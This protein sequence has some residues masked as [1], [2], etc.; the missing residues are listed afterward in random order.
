MFPNFHVPAEIMSE[1]FRYCGPSDLAAAS[2]VSQ[3]WRRAAFFRLHY[4]ITIRKFPHLETLLSRLESEK[5]DHDL[6][7]GLCLRSLSLIM[8][9]TN[10]AGKDLWFEWKDN[11]ALAARVYSVMSKLIQLEGLR[12]MTHSKY[13]SPPDIFGHC[14]N[15]CPNLRW[16]HIAITNW[17]HNPRTTHPRMS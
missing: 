6:R 15:A 1:V 14:R 10:V 17:V 2:R 5:A 8:N 7:I 11:N 3:F 4:T 9:H 12:W 16:I 13:L